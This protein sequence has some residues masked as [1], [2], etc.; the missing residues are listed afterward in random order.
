MPKVAS[1]PL[2][3]DFQSDP[4]PGPLK[5]MPAARGRR[6]EANTKIAAKNKALGKVLRGSWT[7]PATQDAE[8]Q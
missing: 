2:C 5:P 6:Y 3:H 1:V 7:S 8:S 4:P